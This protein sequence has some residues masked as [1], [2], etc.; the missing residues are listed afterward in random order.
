MTEGSYENK[1]ARKLI[2][3]CCVKQDDVFEMHVLAFDSWI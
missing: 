1:H 2:L 3:L